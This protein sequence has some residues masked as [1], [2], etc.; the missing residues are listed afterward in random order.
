[1][2]DWNKIYKTKGVIQ[3]KPSQQIINL[4]SLFKRK[5]I[6]RILDHGCGTG[7]HVKYLTDQGFEVIG[8]DF[9]QKA[10]KE[11]KKLC[12]SAKFVVSDM[13]VVPFD[14]NF[15]DAIICS[16]LIQ[17]GLKESR[18]KAISEMKRTLKP[19]GLILIRTTS[20]TQKSK[21]YKQGK[22]I[23]PFT[24]V[25]IPELPDGKTPHHYFS[26]DELK[27]YFTDFKILSLEHKIHY[28][29]KDD[30]WQM[31]FESLVLLAKKLPG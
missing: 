30:P 18:K 24:Y 14:N 8:T 9:S 17:H 16:H 31:E 22:K 2:Q 3:R 19:K 23:E 13:S 10:I 27:S 21:S 20:R 26:E 11:A 12:L 7:R 6:R 4:V 5:R 15:F 29:T 1:M 25:N 28:P